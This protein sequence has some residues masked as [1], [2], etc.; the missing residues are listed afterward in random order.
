VQFFHPVGFFAGIK[1]TYV[2]QDV[3]TATSAW[4]PY[5]YVDD[6]DSFWV[7]DAAIGYRLPKRYG[8]VSVEAKNLFNAGFHFTDT[9]RANPS[10]QPERVILGKITLYF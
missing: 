5:S 1:G 7:F 2:T 3:T 4:P 9:N 6:S 8:I 10:I